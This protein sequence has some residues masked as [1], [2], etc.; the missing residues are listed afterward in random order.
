MI[1]FSLAATFSSIAW[2]GRVSANRGPLIE[3]T[4]AIKQGSMYIYIY[5]YSAELQWIFYDLASSKLR[6]IKLH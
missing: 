1:H 3:V 4:L 5:T 2:S 6:Y